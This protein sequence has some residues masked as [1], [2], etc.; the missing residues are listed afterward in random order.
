MNSSRKP[1]SRQALSKQRLFVGRDAH[2]ESFR[3]NLRE[4]PQKRSFLYSIWGQSGVGKSTLIKHLRTIAEEESFITVYTSGSEDNTLEVMA[5]CARIFEKQGRKL[6]R[7]SE[8]YKVYLQQIEAIE[9]DPEAPQGLSGFLVRS[10]TKAGFGLAK[11]VP[12]SGV[13]APFLD[14]EAIAKQFAEWTS[15]AA[16]KISNK[17]EVLLVDKPIEQLTPLFLKDLNEIAKNANII[18][19]FDS[20]EHTSS[21]LDSWFREVLLDPEVRYGSL[22]DNVILVLAGIEEIIRRDWQEYEEYIAHWNLKPFTDDEVRQ[23]LSHRGINDCQAVDEILRLSGGLPVWVETLA[24]ENHEDL[25]SGNVSSSSALDFFLKRINEPQKQR[26]ALEASLSPILNRDIITILDSEESAEELYH[27]L[28]SMPF[29]EEKSRDDWSYH[30]IIRT[31]MLRKQRLLSPN[32]WIELHG[33]LANYFDD[34]CSTFRLGNQQKWHDSSC[35]EY[36]FYGLY[37]HLCWNPRQGLLKALNIFLTALDQQFSS[38]PAQK[39]A[40]IISAAGRASAL[41]EIQVL[42]NQL[43]DGLKSFGENRYE[44]GIEMLTLLLTQYNLEKQ[45][46]AIALGWRGEAYRLIRLYDE[47]LQDFDDAISINVNNSWMIVSRSSTYRKMRRYEESIQDCDSA[48]ELNSDDIK[49]FTS[50]G[51][52]YLR[53]KKYDEAIRDLDYAVHLDPNDTWSLASRGNAYQQMR[54]YRKA[55]QDFDRVVEL[56]PNDSWTLSNRGFIYRKRGF[57]VKALEDYNRA[58]EL[59]PYNA[60]LFASRAETYR[61]MREYEQALQDFGRAISLK[62]NDSWAKCRRAETYL[63]LRQ[64]EESF[65]DFEE[66]IILSPDNDWRLFTYSLSLRASGYLEEASAKLSL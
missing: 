64:Y 17:D 5:E 42:G 7:F 41:E 14:E 29:V 45:S 61:L 4:Q 27:W 40:E 51:Q 1:K 2:M 9:A 47:S 60:R 22:P 62:P 36:F 52:T 28:K 13:V 55:M 53:L 46:R 30:D 6:Q 54:Q 24:A 37:H 23:Y 12:G 50:R 35:Q 20:Y 56:D 19:F 44:D 48:I 38:Y 26:V 65:A 59:N 31:P 66:V 25:V 57:Y 3:A 10:I 34:L 39:C 21:F 18:L 63:L 15:Y 32:R 33:K 49:A 11:Q 16:K 8:R 43:L 58:I